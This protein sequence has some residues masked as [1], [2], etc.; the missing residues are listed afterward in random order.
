MAKSIWSG[1]LAGMA[2]GLAGAFVM[3]LASSRLSKLLGA[4]GQGG[5]PDA[6]VLAAE[7]LLGRKLT[8]QER[9]IA[10]QLM[11]Y[12]FGAAMGALYGAARAAGCAR[13]AGAGL[14]FGAAVYLGAHGM[15][16]P[17]LGL[18]ESPLDVPLPNEA[19]ELAAHLVYGAVTDGVRRA[20][21][22]TVS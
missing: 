17:R 16:V 13:G 4:N 10:S 5:G 20:L 8:P 12:G 15:A 2:G 14:G 6:T 9:P 11:H 1:A 7:R 19:A 18:A 22:A 21:L 3:G